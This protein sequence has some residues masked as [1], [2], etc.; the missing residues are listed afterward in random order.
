MLVEKILR[1]LGVEQEIL[2][3]EFFHKVIV[4]KCLCVF[5]ILIFGKTCK[6]KHFILENEQNTVYLH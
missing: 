6:Y 1:S 5:N 3:H 2:V 4:F